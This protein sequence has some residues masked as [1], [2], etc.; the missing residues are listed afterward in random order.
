MGGLV[1]INALSRP[2][3]ADPAS[4]GIANCT[5]GTLF[6]GTPF[7]GS[8]KAKYAKIALAILDYVLL[9]TQRQNVNDLE[10]RSQ[11]LR[12]ISHLFAQFLKARYLSLEQPHLEV[13]CFFE[14][15]PMHK[16]VG[17][18][19]PKDSATWLGENPQSIQANHVNMCRFE[20]NYGSDYKKVAGKLSEWVSNIEVNKKK[21][22]KGGVGGMN[23]DVSH[24]VPITDVLVW[25]HS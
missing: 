10:E 7:E 25:C 13:A 5:I 2:Y 24:F 22:K 16:P 18:V 4:Q 9:P 19:V 3:K 20:D 23:P 21:G 12:G 1:V 15:R 6:L 14:E 8:S 17:F 11:V